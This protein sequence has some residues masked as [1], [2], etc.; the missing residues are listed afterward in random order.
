MGL[1]FFSDL[2]NDDESELEDTDTWEFA[3]QML[4]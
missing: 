3:M 4:D 1:G 2:E